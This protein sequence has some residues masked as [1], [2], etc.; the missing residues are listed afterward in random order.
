M[1]KS[2]LLLSS[3]LFILTSQLFPQSGKKNPF[4]ISPDEIIK[5]MVDSKVSYD[6][7]VV[8]GIENNDNQDLP[9]LNDQLYLQVG[10]SATYL[11]QYKLSEEGGKFYNLAEEAYKAGDYD[12]AIGLYRK[13]TE[14][15]KDFHKVH[16]FIGDMY[17]MKKDY[18]SAKY[19]F[20]LAIEK[21]P[22]DYSAHW[23]LSDTYA[24]T[25]DKEEALKEITI[26]H[27]LNRNHKSIFEKLKQYREDADKDWKEW[28]VAPQCSTYM[29]DKKAVIKT[30]GK[31]LG[32]ACAE[33][34]WK[35]EPGFSERACGKKYDG[36]N[37]IY[38]K[39]AGCLFAN[40]KPKDNDEMMTIV[41][42]GYFQQMVWY[43]VLS[44]K[45]PGALLLMPKDFFAGLIE[46][47][48]KYH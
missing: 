2:I 16:V 34:L 19:Y 48:N 17:Y 39:E 3:A 35:F 20:R 41:K 9:T 5:T 31:W 7:E 38:E 45:T 14:T 23:F 15:D 32:Y 8:D 33:A 46:Y 13:I 27:L 26:A 30:T 4:L 37:A 12:K 11:M 43:E 29:K 44:K 28:E 40:L 24:K 22:I 25:G 21:N 6:L 1:K 47:V 42:D 36:N 18:D 10:D